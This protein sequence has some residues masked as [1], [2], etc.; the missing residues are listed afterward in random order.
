MQESP[1]LMQLLNPDYGNELTSADDLDE[2]QIILQASKEFKV[3]QRDLTVLLITTFA[4]WNY[5]KKPA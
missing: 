3:D 2:N 4:L 1:L 5:Q